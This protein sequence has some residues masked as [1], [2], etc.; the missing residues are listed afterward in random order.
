M[1]WVNLLYELT[2]GH[3]LRRTAQMTHNMADHKGAGA[4]PF[5]FPDS[6]PQGSLHTC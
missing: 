5:A 6:T 4:V 2:G 3:E 1:L